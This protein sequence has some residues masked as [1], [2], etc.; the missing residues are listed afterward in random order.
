MAIRQIATIGC[1]FSGYCSKKDHDNFTGVFTE[2]GSEVI[3]LN[4]KAVCVTGT[5]GRASCGC[6]VQ[7]IGGSK[8]ISLNGKAVARVGDAIEEVGGGGSITGVI[9][10]GVGWLGVD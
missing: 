4:G 7:A 10:S 9:T 8:A 3:S 2:N 1:S 6:W 5:R